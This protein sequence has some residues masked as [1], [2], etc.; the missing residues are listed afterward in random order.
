MSSGRKPRYT[1]WV[2]IRKALEAELRKPSS[3][4]V[5]RIANIDV[6]MTNLQQFG[7]SALVGGY[8]VFYE[9]GA[10]W[11]S[12]KQILSELLIVR[13]QP[14][15]SLKDVARYLE[16]QAKLEGITTVCIGTS[17]ARSDRALSRLWQA[18]GYTQ[19]GI[20]LSKEI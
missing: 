12:D 20:T 14:G 17:F 13:V 1:D 3:K 9:S 11:Y 15:G 7:R 4:L 6:A 16:T 2:H 19:E 18:L 10:P 8:F 5:H